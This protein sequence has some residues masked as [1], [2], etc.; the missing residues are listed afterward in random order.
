MTYDEL[1]QFLAK[2]R[3]E[4]GLSFSQVARRVGKTKAAVAQWEYGKSRP[5][6]DAL[7]EWAAAF[8]YR[9]VMAPVAT[10]V[11]VDPLEVASLVANLD[12][13]DVLRVKHYAQ[14]LEHATE[15]EREMLISMVELVHRRYTDTVA[16]AVGYS[17][18]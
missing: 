7:E 15:Q 10:D 1:I 11:T 16:K 17:S 14:V 18:E 9:I 2:K 6:P 12:D 3:E 8:G 4:K 13:A 5:T